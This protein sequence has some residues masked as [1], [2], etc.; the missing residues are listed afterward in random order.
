MSNFWQRTQTP[1]LGA[2]VEI[3]YLAGQPQHAHFVSKARKY[4][5]LA[6]LALTAAAVYAVLDRFGPSIPGTST[7]LLFT[8]LLG[9]G[10]ARRQ[11]K[12]R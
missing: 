4:Y 12:T 1:G 6:F 2:G 9:L 3:E 10:V 8:L 11:R 5:L 7:F